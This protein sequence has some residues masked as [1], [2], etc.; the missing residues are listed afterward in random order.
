MNVYD[1]VVVGTGFAS[2]FFLKR[3]LD[4]GY[5]GRILVL[6]Q[7]FYDTHSWKLDNNVMRDGLVS[8]SLP[9]E[10]TFINNGDHQWLYSPGFGG[11]S[12]CWG[13]C[14][15]RFLE[16]DFRM[17]SL[18]GVGVDWPIS[19]DDLEPFYKMA[20]SE[21]MIAG[22]EDMLY[23]NFSGYPLPAH[24]M[25][26]FDLLMKQKFPNHY[27]T[28]PTARPSINIGNRSR[29]C[30]TGVCNLCPVDSKFTITNS[31]KNIYEKSNVD[32]IF[33][34]KAYEIKHNQ[35]VDSLSYFKDGKSYSVSSKAVILGANA[36]FNPYILINSGLNHPWLGKGL[37]EQISINVDIYLKDVDSL[38]GSTLITG[39]GY[40]LYDNKSRK[41][42]SGALIEFINVTRKLRMEKGKLTH[43][44]P[45]RV[46]LE[47]LPDQRN[48][49]D[50]VNN[51]PRANYSGH[52]EYVTKAIKNL[53]VNLESVFMN[54]DFVESIQI[55]SENV[56]DAH[57]IG[58]VRMGDTIDQGVVNKYQQHHELPNLF[59]LGG[60]SFPTMSPANPTLTI[61]A[62]S[63]M[64]ADYFMDNLDD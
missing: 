30:A 35:K 61:S 15:P 34:A 52:S 26:R 10:E 54:L 43:I 2:S 59:V 41:D 16:S 57:I 47:D 28:Q 18:Y 25:N 53:T 62:L 38:N 39:L 11:S 5:K 36:L 9:P 51:K 1:L 45:I 31:L 46:I 48:Y 14:T 44:A 63:L 20:E 55:G 17:N 58:T 33:G 8:T 37:S 49:V 42:Y 13:A 64:S 32:I 7:G 56:S 50:I 23:K 21:L 19:Y 6:E 27:F 12:N 29:C 4:K 60:S 3:I 40:M 22:S 24:R